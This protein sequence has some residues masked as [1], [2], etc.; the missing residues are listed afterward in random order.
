MLFVLP[1]RSLA[2]KDAKFLHHAFIRKISRVNLLPAKGLCRKNS[3]EYT[4]YISDFTASDEVRR[5]CHFEIPVLP[6]TYASCPV[7]SSANRPGLFEVVVQLILAV[8]RSRC[9][10]F[11]RHSLPRS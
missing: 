11:A 3:E 7:G 1:F 5:N 4:T 6:K 9:T 8:L 10:G 2:A